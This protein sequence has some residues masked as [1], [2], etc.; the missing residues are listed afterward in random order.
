M[1]NILRI[2][3]IQ[4]FLPN[5]VLLQSLLTDDNKHFEKP[6]RNFHQ[7]MEEENA[8]KKRLSPE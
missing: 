7:K 4:T 8:T 6:K 1:A 5:L 3:Q 2:F